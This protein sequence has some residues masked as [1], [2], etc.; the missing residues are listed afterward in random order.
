MFCLCVGQLWWQG[1]GQLASTSAGSLCRSLSLTRRGRRDRRNGRKSGNLKTQ[2]V[3]RQTLTHR[4]HQTSKIHT[5]VL[6]SACMFLYSSEAPEEEYDPRSLFERLQEQKDKKQE[7]YEEQFKFSESLSLFLFLTS[8]INTFTF[9]FHLFLPLYRHKEP[10]AMCCKHKHAHSVR[11]WHHGL[12][13]QFCTIQLTYRWLWCT[14]S[15]WSAKA[16]ENVR[17]PLT[18]CRYCR[19]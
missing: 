19:I 2:K 18:W 7:D 10:G 4:M 14:N 6:T 15:H 16:G 17:S 3:R 5:A 12:S 8:V 11:G 9:I 13:W 1:A